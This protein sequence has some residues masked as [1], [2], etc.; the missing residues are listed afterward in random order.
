MS[1]EVSGRVLHCEKPVLIKNRGFSWEGDYEMERVN[2]ECS[3]CGAELTL[4][5]SANVGPPSGDVA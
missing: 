2:M 1:R 3:E 5:I 4:T